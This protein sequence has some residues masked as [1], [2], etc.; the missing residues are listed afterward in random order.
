[1]LNVFF[2]MYRESFEAILIV[3]ILYA[4]LTRQ[5]EAKA[6]LRYMWAGV[7]GGVALSGLL[8]WGLN[9]AQNEFQGQALEH[10]NN[11]ILA[12]AIVL[13]TH[14][15]IWMKQNARTLKG[16][17]Q[18]GLDKSIAKS[19]YWEVS[20]LAM[21]AVGREGS[22]TVIFLYGMATEAIEKHQMNT[23]LQM[24]GLGLLASYATWIVFSKGMK[25]FKQHVFFQFTTGILLLTASNLTL[26]LTRKLIQSDILPS[27]KDPFWDSSFL[28]DERTEFGQVFSS[29]TGY[30]STPALMTVLIYV[31]YWLITMYFYRRQ[32][33][34]VAQTQKSET[35]PLSMKTVL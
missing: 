4:Y 20:L 19:H 16:N 35:S 34:V 8:A 13:M 25:F 14:M 15:C 10:F 1:M 26:V 17:L 23:F 22:E 11:I 12:T 21:L 33:K 27:L 31:A 30:Q 32:P 9:T 5:S 7:M 18:S 2:V 28:I 29:V 24:I 3:G 6:A